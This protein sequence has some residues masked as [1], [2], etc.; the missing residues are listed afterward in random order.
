MKQSK[1]VDK[2]C[3]KIIVPHSKLPIAEY[4]GEGHWVIVTNSDLKF[5]SVCPTAAQNKLDFIAKPPINTIKTNMQ[6]KAYN[7]HIPKELD[8]IKEI[9]RDSLIDW[10]QSLSNYDDINVDNDR[11]PFWPILIAIIIVCLTFGIFIF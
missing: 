9:P 11:I 2:L 8:G 5:V 7:K 3:T 10:L 4:L 6:C 1:K